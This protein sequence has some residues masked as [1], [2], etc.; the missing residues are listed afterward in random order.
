MSV[1]AALGV[2]VTLAAAPHFGVAV[3]ALFGAEQGVIHG[4][5]IIALSILGAA[6]IGVGF[7][8]MLSEWRGF[9]AFEESLRAAEKDLTA[10]KASLRRSA[11]LSRPLGEQQGRG[12]PASATATST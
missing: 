10:A 3:P 9:G 6:L 5:V 2:V 8:F 11:H 1:V 12:K 4:S 7:Q